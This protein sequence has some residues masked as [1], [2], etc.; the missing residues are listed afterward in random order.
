MRGAAK[1]RFSYLTMGKRALGLCWKADEGSAWETVRICPR[2]TRRDVL[3]SAC[4][5]NH[6]RISQ[7]SAL[8]SAIP[9]HSFLLQI[10]ISPR[11][12]Y[13][14]CAAPCPATQKLQ[15]HVLGQVNQGFCPFLSGHLFAPFV[16]TALLS[17]P[18]HALSF[19]SPSTSDRLGGSSS[20]VKWQVNLLDP[21]ALKARSPHFVLLGWPVRP[22]PTIIAQPSKSLHSAEY[23]SSIGSL[24]CS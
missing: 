13:G 9:R 8:S 5:Q 11:W 18:S 10:N 15:W 20:A 12:H 14:S 3:K 7:L 22:R 1:G 6:L 4:R 16:R 2:P 23:T 24:P 19:S 21:V 17:S